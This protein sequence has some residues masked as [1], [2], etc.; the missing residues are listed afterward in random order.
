[1]LERCERPE[2]FLQGL[3]CLI[4]VAAFAGSAYAQRM[5]YSNPE[6]SA[7]ENSNPEYASPESSDPEPSDP[8]YADPEASDFDAR[9]QAADLGNDGVDRAVVTDPSQEADLEPY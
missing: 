9:G 4:A 3:L 2:R 1:M 5:E 7:P 6:Y 8:E